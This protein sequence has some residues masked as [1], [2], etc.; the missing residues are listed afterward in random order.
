MFDYRTEDFAQSVREATGGREVDVIVDFVGADYLART[1]RSLAPGGRLVQ[2]GLLG[3]QDEASVPLSLVLHDHLRLIGTVMKSRAAQEKRVMVRRFAEGAL[4]MFADGR[5]KHW[6]ARCSRAR[7]RPR[8]IAGWRPAADSGRSC[9]MWPSEAAVARPFARALGIYAGSRQPSR[10]IARG[11]WRGG[12]TR[13]LR[14]SL[15]ERG[16][17]LFRGRGLKQDSGLRHQSTR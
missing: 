10:H 6:S 7:K 2:V 3:G 11:A 13:P 5:L 1:L 4:P 8:R 14:Q 15:L 17:G 16:A 12:G 9:S